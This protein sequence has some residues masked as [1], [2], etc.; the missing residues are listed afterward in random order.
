MPTAKWRLHMFLIHA[1]VERVRAWARY[2]LTVR[3]LSDL[4]DRDLSDLGI[5]RT[6]IESVARRHAFA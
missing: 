1:L 2:R 6:E 5:S 3:E 4:S